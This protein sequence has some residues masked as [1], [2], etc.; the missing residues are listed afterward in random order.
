M[1]VWFRVLRNSRHTR[2][3]HPCIASPS[4]RE[5]ENNGSFIKSLAQDSSTTNSRDYRSKTIKA[6]TDLLPMDKIESI[7]HFGGDVGGLRDSE[8]LWSAFLIR[9]ESAS[10]IIHYSLFIIH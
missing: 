1:L 10:T 4:L 8:R 5:I 6:N 9:A 2:L 7:R 3:M